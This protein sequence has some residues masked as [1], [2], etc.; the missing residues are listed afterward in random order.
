LTAYLQT[1]DVGLSGFKPNRIQIE[2]VVV[3]ASGSPLDLR[4]AV[5]AWRSRHSAP[6]AFNVPPKPEIRN[7][8]FTWQALA[9]TAPFLE[10]NGVTFSEPAKPYGP[11]G[12]DVAVRLNARKWVSLVWLRLRLWFTMKRSPVEIGLGGTDWKV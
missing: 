1:V 7:I 4:R 10:L 8:K 3:Q 9:N 12:E 6:A 5:Q 2:G 11:I